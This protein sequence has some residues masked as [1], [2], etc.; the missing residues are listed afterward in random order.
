MLNIR[1][2]VG[3]R[4]KQTYPGIRQNKPDTLL[5]IVHIKDDPSTTEVIQS[6]RT[7]RQSLHL[8]LIGK[9]GLFGS[10]PA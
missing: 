6:A 3:L 8:I 4:Q 2:A 10:C 5:G 1:M 7:M 9:R